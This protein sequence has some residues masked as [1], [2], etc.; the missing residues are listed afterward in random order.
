MN[1]ITLTAP[2]A[3]A[4]YLINGDASGIE[5]A[6]QAQADAWIEHVGMGSPVGCEDAGF[7]HHH[8]ARQFAHCAADCQTYT[9][10]DHNAPGDEVRESQHE[11]ASATYQ[12]LDWLGRS[13][14]EI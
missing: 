1:T 11:L 2:S 7:I 6:E 9:F 14:D 12:Q 4:S 3:W 8:D 13:L 10:Y 5:D